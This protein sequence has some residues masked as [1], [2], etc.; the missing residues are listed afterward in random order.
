MTNQLDISIQKYYSDIQKISQEIGKMSLETENICQ[1]PLLK[2]ILKDL[3][4]EQK[5]CHKILYSP[6]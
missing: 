5:F 1:V 6:L 3:N 2:G 4:T